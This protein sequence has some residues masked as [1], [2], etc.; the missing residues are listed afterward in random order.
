MKAEAKLERAA[1]ARPADTRRRV[2]LVE[3]DPDI[4]EAIVY[5]LEKAGL[6]VKVA[7]TG[8]EGLEVARRGCDLV[9][10]CNQSVDGGAAVDALLDGLEA[11]HAQ[12]HWQRNPD[13]EARR[14]RLLPQT[15]PLAWD[16]LMHDPLYQRALERL[17]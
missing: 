16:D 6:Q 17:P 14:Q 13:S 5:H 7:R 11:Q 8:E 3:D 15:A 4:A 1:D 2:L 10:L 9:L 12:G